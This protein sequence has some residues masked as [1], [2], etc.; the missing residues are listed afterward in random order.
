MTFV[1][2]I[3]AAVTE[4]SR[5]ADAAQGWHRQAAAKGASLRLIRELLAIVY[6][7]VGTDAIARFLAEM[8]GQREPHQRQNDP[9]RAFSRPTNLSIISLNVLAASVRLEK[10]DSLYMTVAVMAGPRCK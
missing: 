4:P 5:K 10:N 6:L 3:H 8:K 9:G 7:T 1:R 2:A